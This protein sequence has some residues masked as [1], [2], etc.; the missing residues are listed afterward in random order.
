[1]VHGFEQDCRISGAYAMMQNTTEFTSGKG[2]RPFEFH[3]NMSGQALGESRYEESICK[4]ERIMQAVRARG[5][6]DIGIDVAGTGKEQRHEYVL[7]I[8]LRE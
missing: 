7:N 6:W 2:P 3:K 5:E 8:C 4:G 1:M